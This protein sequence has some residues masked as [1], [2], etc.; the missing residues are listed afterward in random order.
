MDG[1]LDSALASLRRAVAVLERLDRKYPGVLNYQRGLASTYNLMSD[2]YRR[3][4]E[5]ADSLAWAEKGRS[6]LERLVGEHPNEV[7]ARTDL[8]R[9]YNNIG[10]VHQQSGETSEALRAYQR[11]VDLYE[12]LPELGPRNCCNL[13]CNLALSIPLIGAKHGSTGELDPD[14]VPPGDRVRRQV[15][16]DR[17]ID[18]IRRAVRGG[19]RDTEILQTDPDLAAIRG[20]DDFQEIVKEA[21]K[22]TA[23]GVK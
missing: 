16:G 9:S 1:K 8:A 10:R 19:F 4:L 13:A 15:Y 22:Q 11:A 14:A 7:E 20:R 18:V 3:R 5:S 2:L 17:A 23:A 6:L 21:G 12:G